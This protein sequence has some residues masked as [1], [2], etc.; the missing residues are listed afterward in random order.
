MHEKDSIKVE[1]MED[2]SLPQLLKHRV[3]DESGLPLL[4]Q[5]QLLEGQPK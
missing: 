4:R 2:P 3:L 1:G 5:P